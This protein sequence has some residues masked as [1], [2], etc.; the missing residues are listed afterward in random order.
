MLVTPD[1]TG[2]VVRRCASEA[3]ILSGISHPNVVKI[4]GICILPPSVCI[5]LEVC[6]YGSLAD[7]IRSVCMNSAQVCVL[8]LIDQI[9]VVL[10]VP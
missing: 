8:L 9:P 1:L 6:Q 3:E 2:D 5:V 10:T 4:Y 7:V